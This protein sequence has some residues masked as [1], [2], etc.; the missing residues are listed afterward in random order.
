MADHVQT[1]TGADL[2]HPPV[3]P[4]VATGRAPAGGHPSPLRILKP[5]QGI[6][7]RWGTAGGAFALAFGAAYFIY[8]KLVFIDFIERNYTLR[9]TIPIIVLLALTWL[10]FWAVAR[11]PKVVDFLIATEGEMKKVNW[12]SRKEVWGATKVVIVT[13]LSL[14]FILFVVDIA[15]IFF[16]SS[17]KV[18]HFDV[19]RELFGIGAQQ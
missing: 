7:V 3:P 8:N 5:G 11:Q 14:A 17:I 16:F 1:N 4:P 10:I 12:S 9:T 18:L 2:T 6:H 13:V 19:L 15:F